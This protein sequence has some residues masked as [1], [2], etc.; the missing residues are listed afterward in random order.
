MWPKSILCSISVFSMTIG[1]A[2]ADEDHQSK[3]Y[4]Q[5]KSILYYF[6]VDGRLVGAQDIHDLSLDLRLEHQILFD[7]K[8]LHGIGIGQ[9]D[10]IK[11][12][13]KQLRQKARNISRDRKTKNEE[14]VLADWNKVI[15]SFDNRVS[16]LLTRREKSKLEECVL[17]TEFFQMGLDDFVKHKTGNKK[18]SDYSIEISAKELIEKQLEIEVEVLEILLA[19]VPE[20]SRL[21]IMLALKDLLPK[22]KPTLSVLW[23]SLHRLENDSEPFDEKQLGTT[24][25]FELKSGRLNSNHRPGKSSGDLS[26]LMS[27]FS[28][29]HPEQELIRQVSSEMFHADLAVQKEYQQ[30]INDMGGYKEVGKSVLNQLREEEWDKRLEANERIF[31]QLPGHLQRNIRFAQMIAD[32]SRMGADAAFCTKKN[33]ERMELPIEQKHIRKMRK[34]AAKAK[35]HLEDRV[36]S[37]VE[38]TYLPTLTEI[39]GDEKENV[40]WLTRKYPYQIPPTELMILWQE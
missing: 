30:R 24:P 2:T 6:D 37:L 34:S 35:K 21:E 32:Y 16:K 20:A 15:K 17:A 39:F 19:P 33:L 22:R 31:S 23:N 13:I 38:E 12:E 28:L 26:I 25:R 36:Q 8:L 10:K 5:A 27:H 18:I 1:L 9:V 7:L 40:S 3:I 11:E 29:D 4:K 14:E